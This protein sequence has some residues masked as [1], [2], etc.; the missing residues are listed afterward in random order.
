MT[1]ERNS[2]VD[3]IGSFLRARFDIFQDIA[4]R[5]WFR[6]FGLIWSVFGI[7]WVV[8]GAWDLILSQFVPEEYSRHLPKL[9][10]MVGITA[11]WL[12]LGV[13]LMLGAL[14]VIGGAVEWAFRH[15][16]RYLELLHQNLITPSAANRDRTI[17][18]RKLSHS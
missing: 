6:V 1:L 12:S 17:P 18:F 10:Q 3:P 5:P 15:K 4:D 2:S 16:K 9:Y 8:A 11:G 13:W 7:I 14:L